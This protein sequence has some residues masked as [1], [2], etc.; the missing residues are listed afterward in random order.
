MVELLANQRGDRGGRAGRG[1]TARNCKREEYKKAVK[2]TNFHE[3]LSKTRSFTM[4]TS[5]PMVIL[6]QRLRFGFCHEF[7]ARKRRRGGGKAKNEGE[8][9]DHG[10]G[11]VEQAIPASADAIAAYELSHE[12]YGC[13][14]SLA[15]VERAIPA[16]AD[17]ISAQIT[18][19]QS[20]EIV[21]TICGGL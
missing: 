16:S 6:V 2:L 18:R 7:E 17:A 11:P 14:Y 4:P 8:Y 10:S 1:T 15:R 20:K 19:T 5:K 13:G 3:F 12:S 21:G 9:P